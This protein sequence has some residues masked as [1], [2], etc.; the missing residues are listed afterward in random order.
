[1]N[2]VRTKI[3]GVTSV[4][5]A[6]AAVAAGADAIGLVFAAASARR[7][8]IA[9]AATIAAAVPPFVARVALFMD[10]AADEITAVLAAVE[11]DVIQFH[12][13]ETPEF[14]EGFARP[15]IKA[16]PMGEPG[17]RLADWARRHPHAAGFL[18]DANRIG[19]AGGQGRTFDWSDGLDAIERPVVVAGGLTADN[20]ATAIARF[21]PYAVDVSSGVEREPGIKCNERMRA[22]VDAVIQAGKA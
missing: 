4:A 2:R 9:R 10:N 6:Q 19:E 21:T 3:C 5:D 8:D 17:V 20:V 16:V 1:M 14:C 15:Y 22:F 13:S 12:G 7:I 18:V 11:I